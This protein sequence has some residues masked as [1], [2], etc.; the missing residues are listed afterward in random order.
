MLDN[1][2]FNAYTAKVFVLKKDIVSQMV[3]YKNS[4]G[5]VADCYKK[6][7]LDKLW[8]LS[9][10]VGEHYIKCLGAISEVEADVSDANPLSQT[11]Y[12]LEEMTKLLEEQSLSDSPSVVIRSEPS[13]PHLTSL[14]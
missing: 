10:V 4:T 9:R 11:R 14:S 1:E 12:Q 2:E 7:I 8:K 3:G 13:L 6:V 5:D